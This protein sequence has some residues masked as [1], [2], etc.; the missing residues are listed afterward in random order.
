MP[1]RFAMFCLLLLPLL[2]LQTL[3]KEKIRWI[4]YPEF[5]P[6]RIVSGPLAGRGIIDR[7]LSWLISQLDGFDH[8]L[9]EAT[10]LRAFREIVER[11]GQCVIDVVQTPERRDIALFSRVALIHRPP[12]IIIRSDRLAAL[13]PARLP[14]G[15][16][17]LGRLAEL[18]GLAGA[19][20]EDRN[21]G[22][23]ISHFL[24]SD[25]QELTQLLNVQQ[26]LAMMSHGRIDYTF[27]YSSEVLYYQRVSASPAEITFVPIAG[28]ATP[29]PVYI[30]CSRGSVGEKAIAAIDRVLDGADGPV[31][32]LPELR[33][34]FDPEEYRQ[35]RDFTNWRSLADAGEG[36]LK[37]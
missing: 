28:G 33:E 4:V 22:P 19:I 23:A 5:P 2:P 8:V 20:A 11:D 25:H 37:R 18:A 14:D 34:W 1:N 17:D 16:I 30:A 6:A 26:A 31:P 32:Y 10:N 9:V 13:A 21:F 29:M 3:A 36:L 15:T 12:G 7:Q 35:M 24:A 27:G